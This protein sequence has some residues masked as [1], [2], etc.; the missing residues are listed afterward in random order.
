M[1]SAITETSSLGDDS[2][3][4]SLVDVASAEYIKET[5]LTG[6]DKRI[7]SCKNVGGEKKRVGH[8]RED[9]FKKQYNPD[10]MNEPTEY[11]ATSDTWIPANAPI[12]SILRDTFGFE[13]KELNF[14]NKSGNNIQ[15]TL[16]QIPELL[17]EENLEWIKNGD[18]SRSLFNKYLKKDS[19]MRP[20]DLLVYKD[21]KTKK[22][23]FFKMDDI[24]EFIVSQTTWRKLN[25][26]RIKG[27]INNDS[28][29]GFGQYLTYEYRTNHKSYFL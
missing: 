29:K 7:Q 10:S 9:D 4:K 16:G 8:K 1:N 21:N 14:S 18:N 11:K 19:S 27:D 2:M 17:C 3:W 15:F 22:W 12:A 28:K 6:N 26:G 20:A 25:S 5:A 23:V 13:N 24:I